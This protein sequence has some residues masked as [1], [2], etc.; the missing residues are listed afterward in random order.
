[1]DLV[2]KFAKISKEIDFDSI[3]LEKAIE[4]LSWPRILGDYEGKEISVAIGKYGPY[5]KYDGTFTSISQDSG[6]VAETI[7][8]DEALELI[9]DSIKEKKN[10]V[11]KE[12]KSK[13]IFVLNGKYGPYIKK[14][15]KNYKIPEYKE[16][17]ELTLKDCEEIIKNSKK[18]KKK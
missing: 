14:G 12:Y 9:K 15:K 6:Y 8:F 16:A 2:T 4:L 13:D 10:R 7:N 17:K 3:S 5:V 18:R 1:M 11:I